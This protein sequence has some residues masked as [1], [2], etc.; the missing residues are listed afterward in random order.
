[1]TPPSGWQPCTSRVGLLTTGRILS[2]IASGGVCVVAPTYLGEIA[3][4]HMRGTLGTLS[5][6]TAALGV[7]AGLLLGFPAGLGSVGAWPLMLG[8]TLLPALLQLLLQPMLLETPRWYV[9]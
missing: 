7:L 9:T 5:Q 6:L 8:L 4:A 3:P 1:M 2:G